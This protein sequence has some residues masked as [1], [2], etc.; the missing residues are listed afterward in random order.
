LERLA[1]KHPA[2]IPEAAHA[3]E[4]MIGKPHLGGFV[5][6][7]GPDAGGNYAAAYLELLIARTMARCGSVHGLRVLADYVDD[8]Q[9][10][11]ARY[12]Y[13]TLREITGRSLERSSAAWKLWID[14]QRAQAAQS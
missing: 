12:A 11:L 14:G 1:G 7:T 10:M 3:L 13:D 6:T 9:A 5:A 2:G 4:A 8:V